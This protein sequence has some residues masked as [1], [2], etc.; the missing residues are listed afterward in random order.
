M[1]RF[2]NVVSRE[3]IKSFALG[4]AQSAAMPIANFIAPTV[5]VSAMVGYYKSYSEKNRFRIPDTRRGYGG[6]AAMLQFDAADVTF[7]CTPHA[8]DYA[9]DK[10]EQVGNDEDAVKEA[11]VAVAEVA[12][13]AG[14][15]TVIDLALAAAGSGTNSNFTS[16][17][18]DPVAVLD[19][20]ILAV[21]KAAKY[22]SAMGVRVLFGATAFSRFRNN[23][24][25]RGRFVSG[26]ASKGAAPTI[27]TP[28]VTDVGTLL[29]GG[30]KAEVSY[31]VYDNAAEGLAE[32][33]QF[34]LDTAI[35]IFACKDTPTRRDPSFMKTFRLMGNW[36]VPKT[37][38]RDDGRVDVVGFDWSEDIKVTN[39]AAVS[40]INATNS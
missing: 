39:S 35:L 33:I 19:E 30:P 12:S 38:Q 7:N 14:E 27:T 22:G 4:A 23:A 17:G 3:T 34:V 24:N 21:L 10:L 16:S 8:L 13:L 40:R 15:K 1:S 31:M 20:Q 25:V 18:V 9:V 11:A 5:D 36:M 37:Y 32:S 28:Q 29:L 2:A 26:L 6:R